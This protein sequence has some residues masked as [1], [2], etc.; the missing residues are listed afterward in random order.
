MSANIIYADR[1]PLIRP[2]QHP[3]LSLEAVALWF[4]EKECGMAEFRSREIIMVILEA[5][6][7]DSRRDKC[8]QRFCRSADHNTVRTRRVGVPHCATF[9]AVPMPAGNKNALSH[10]LLRRFQVFVHRCD[11]VGRMEREVGM[12]HG[13]GIAR[14]K[15]SFEWILEFIR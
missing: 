5:R 11:G 7:L 9:Y 1:F 2:K 8:V 4:V 15:A 13:H 14:R 6:F 3:K 12:R 10:D